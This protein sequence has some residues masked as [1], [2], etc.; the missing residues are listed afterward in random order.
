MS[1]FLTF[2]CLFVSCASFLR[3][4]LVYPVILL[5]SDLD[6]Q[7]LSIVVWQNGMNLWNSK[8]KVSECSVFLLDHSCCWNFVHHGTFVFRLP[9]AVAF[10]NT[11]QVTAGI[12]GEWMHTQIFIWPPWRP[13]PGG[14]VSCLWRFHCH[15]YE[16]GEQEDY[17]GQTDLHGLSSHFR[18]FMETLF[19]RA[20]LGFLK[21]NVLCA[22]L[23]LC[24]AK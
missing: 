23:L 14:G 22:V 8:Y 20:G 6:G 21:N 5:T 24:I 17:V 15:L 10:S 2:F 16:Y 11:S 9:W 19:A 13:W 18:V 12:R 1:L 7:S 3:Y 4:L